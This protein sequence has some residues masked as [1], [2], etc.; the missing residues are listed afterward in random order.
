MIPRYLYSSNMTPVAVL[1]EHVRA[2]DKNHLS[3]RTTFDVAKPLSNF[4][5]VKSLLR[6][7]SCC[8]LHR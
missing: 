6:P 4:L 8:D 1:D 2:V 3:I 5:L 7:S